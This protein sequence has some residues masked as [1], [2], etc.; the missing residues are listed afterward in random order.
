MPMAIGITCWPN[1]T[2][3]PTQLVSVL[4]ILMAPP[5][6]PQPPCRWDTAPCPV[7][8]KAIYLSVAT[9]YPWSSDNRN[10]AGVIDEVQVSG[11]LVTPA[12]GQ[13]GFI[14]GVVTPKITGISVSRGTVTITF[15]G[16]S[17]EC[18]VEVLGGCC[19]HHWWCVCNHFCHDHITWLW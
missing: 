19:R 8:R 17:A 3:Q 12:S 1:T 10:F 6:L 16:S 2:R 4:P 11:G 7:I 15:A 18:P 14:A 5:L 9:D 13:L